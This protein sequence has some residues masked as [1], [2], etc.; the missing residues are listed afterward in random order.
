M[1]KSIVVLAFILV[2]LA[3][4][5]GLRAAPPAQAK[6][7]AAVVHPATKAERIVLEGVRG[8]IQEIGNGIAAVASG[9]Q[10]R[11]RQVADLI[12]LA[13]KIDRDIE[14]VVREARVSRHLP[15]SISLVDTVTEAGI[16][17]LE[18]ASR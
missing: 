8:R 2:A 17:W 1:K 15:E 7:N 16:A 3:V 18:T 4:W 12:M 14:E 5:G 6:P 13:G 11:A 9:D 10:R